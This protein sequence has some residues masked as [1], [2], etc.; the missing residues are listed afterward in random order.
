MVEISSDKLFILVTI[1]NIAEHVLR[2]FGD[3]VP[4]KIFGHKM[5]EVIGERRKLHNEKLNDLYT[6]P[7]II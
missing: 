6:L 4:R 3:R 2:V 5:E 1:K 7:N